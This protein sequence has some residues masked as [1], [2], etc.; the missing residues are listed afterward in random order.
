LGYGIE[1]KDIL[2]P[3]QSKLMGEEAS[4]G[5][6]KRTYT[7]KYPSQAGSPGVRPRKAIWR[8]P[9]PKE[10]PVKK[11][12]QFQEDNPMKD[13]QKPEK[14]ESAIPGG[15]WSEF[16]K[17]VDVPKLMRTLFV[18]GRGTPGGAGGYWLTL[19]ELCV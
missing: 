6:L 13:K 10:A 4:N 17:E 9:W 15:Y 16:T 3:R 2:P 18:E 11:P 7:N 12:V 5:G 14:R 1:P 8:E 19:T